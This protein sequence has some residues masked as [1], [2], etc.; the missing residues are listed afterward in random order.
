[1][2]TGRSTWSSPVCVLHTCVPTSMSQALIHRAHC[3]RLRES[4]Q[5]KDQKFGAHP[6][7]GRSSQALLAQ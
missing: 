6:V 7:G 5:R 2:E 4:W 1:M 3:S